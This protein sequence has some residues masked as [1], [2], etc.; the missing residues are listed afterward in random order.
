[1]IMPSDALTLH[2]AQLVCS[3]SPLLAD[4]V[5]D[6]WLEAGTPW[7]DIDLTQHCAGQLYATG[8]LH[9]QNIGPVCG[10]S[11]RDRKRGIKAM[12]K[13]AVD[14][15]Q[16]VGILPGSWTIGWLLIRWVIVPF[17]TS[18]IGSWIEDRVRFSE[19]LNAE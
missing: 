10:G 12:R 3:A 9:A 15:L 19:L 7:A 5:T 2:E 1:M 18:L 16:I 13:E 11:K 4:A 17:L 8:W 14:E 6:A